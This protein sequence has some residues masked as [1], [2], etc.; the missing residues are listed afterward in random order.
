MREIVGD[1]LGN[2]WVL[3]SFGADLGERDRCRI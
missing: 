3:N 2:Y 1:S